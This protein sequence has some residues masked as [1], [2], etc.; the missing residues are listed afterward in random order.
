MVTRKLYAVTIKLAELVLIPHSKIPN[1]KRIPTGWGVTV[2]FKEIRQKFFNPNVVKAIMDVLDAREII[3]PTTWHI[4]AVFEVPRTFNYLD[5][6][7]DVYNVIQKEITVVI[8]QQPVNWYISKHGY[9]PYTVKNTFLECRNVRGRLK[10]H[11]KLH[12]TTMVARDIAKYVAAYGKRVTEKPCKT[13]PKCVNCHGHFPSGYKNCPARPLV[14]NRKFERLLQRKL[15]GI[16]K[17]GRTNRAAIINDRA[18]AARRKPAP[19][20]PV[21]STLSQHSQTLNSRSSILNKKA[22][23]YEAAGADIRNFLQ[24]K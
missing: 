17:I 1:A 3:I 10:N 8:G 21:L 22:R 20:I 24:I 12:I 4:Y 5:G 19:A 16:R 15:K 11:A 7:K 18:K 23:P 14:V 2:A 9:D 13:A 6:R